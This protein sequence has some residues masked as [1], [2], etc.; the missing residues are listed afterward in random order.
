MMDWAPSKREAEQ[1][2]AP[3]DRSKA[4]RTRTARI[5][6][7]QAT[8]AQ[9]WRKG[10]PRRLRSS[11][12][13]QLGTVCPTWHLPLL[14]A[15]AQKWKKTLEKGRTTTALR[16]AL[17]GRLIQMLHTGLKDIG[18]KGSTPFQKKA[19][20]M[21]WLKDGH[22]CYQKW[23]PALGSLV[24]DETTAAAHQAAGSAAGRATA[25]HAAPHDTSIPCNQ[26]P[27]GQHDRS[28]HLPTRC[29]Q[30][31]GRTSDS[32]GVS[33]DN[34]GPDGTASHWTPTPPR[35]PRLCNKHFSRLL[36]IRLLNSSNTCYINAS[37]R[38]WL[39]A[40]SHLQVADILKSASQEQAWGDVYHARRPIH[41][42]ALKSWRALLR[43]W[44]NEST[45]AAR[46]L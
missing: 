19:E 46:C 45:H 13:Q 10:A 27:H 25:R 42:H 28:H 31:H 8:L 32:M 5:S 4:P 40:V 24:V 3:S 7:K 17:F 36:L 39:F 16:T 34:D 14:F 35:L 21:K 22:W 41:A 9:S 1:E 6:G 11:R 12:R 15:A 26:A 38:T 30:P 43:N 44:A 37:V 29:L 33:R 18:G 20:E 23:S 2:G